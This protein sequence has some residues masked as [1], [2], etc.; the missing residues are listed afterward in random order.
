LQDASFHPTS[1]LFSSIGTS[2]TDN[3][4]R[5]DFLAGQFF[6]IR[7]EV[8]APLNGSEATGNP[9]A[10]E[11]FTLT[12]AKGRQKPVPATEFFKLTEPKLEHWN[13][14]WYEGKN[15]FRFW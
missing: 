8:H 9:K 1:T 15:R 13:F 6:D 10:D 7:L 5:A 12:I 14:S 4:T 2:Y 11:R 3:A